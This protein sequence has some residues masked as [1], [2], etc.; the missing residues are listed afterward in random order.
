MIFDILDTTTEL[1]MP[2]YIIGEIFSS[3]GTT[4]YKNPSDQTVYIVNFYNL[5]SKYPKYSI[6]KIKKES[7]I[8]TMP[9]L[10][11]MYLPL[12]KFLLQIIDD[13]PFLP[14]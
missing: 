1:W 9:M 12:S 2:K 7:G 8:R 11:R 13:N 3:G 10:S 14:N 6:M 5:V 4:L